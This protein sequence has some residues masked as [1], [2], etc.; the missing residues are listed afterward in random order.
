MAQIV[1]R[2]TLLGAMGRIWSRVTTPAQVGNWSIP[3]SPNRIP[4]VRITNWRDAMQIPAVFRAVSVMTSS[5]GLLPWSV[6][7]KNEKGEITAQERN[8][9]H[10]LLHDAPND[11]M[12]AFDFR[13]TISYHALLQ[14]NGYAEIERN[15]RGQPTAMYLIDDPDR[16]TPGRS[17]TS[18]RLIYEIRQ[19]NGGAVYLPARDVFHVRG[20]LSDDGIVGIGL[21]SFAARNLA[22]NIA[23]EKV[24]EKYFTQGLRTPGFLK[25]KAG[26]AGI[27]SIKEMMQIIREE[28]TGLNNFE[29]PIP[30]DKDTD[31]QPAGSNLKDAEFTDLRKLAILDVCRWIGVPPHLAYDLDKATFSNIE[32]QDLSFLRYSALPRI[33]PMEQE[34]NIKLLSN[35]HGGLYSQMD[36][37]EFSR[38]DMAARIAFY[39]GMSNIGAYSPNDVLRKEG[40]STFE[41]GDTRTKQAQYQDVTKGGGN[42][43]AQDPAADPPAAPSNVR[44]LPR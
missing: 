12:G 19:P 13:K 34:A 25:M 37:N 43:G 41:G 5:V 36:V 15:E 8:P 35:R 39:T 32:A 1:K 16:V 6:L 14:G 24:G 11:E 17:K 42:G 33:T 29:M 9:I 2:P 21:L 27:K 28:M 4:G 3:L 30:V 26:P 20:L 10:W 38:G 18:G 31:F 44:Q 7:K 40:E 23:M 22:L